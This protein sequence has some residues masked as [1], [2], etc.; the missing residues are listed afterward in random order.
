MAINQEILRNISQAATRGDVEQVH[1]AVKLHEVYQ[2]AVESGFEDYPPR[3]EQQG[4]PAPESAPE[5]NSG[6]KTVFSDEHRKNLGEAA[7]RAWQDPEIRTRRVEGSRRA[8]Q[9]PE[10]RARRVEAIKKGIQKKRGK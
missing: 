2:Q 4:S 10:T 3:E 8:W 6:A 9:D 5:G 7:R 1:R